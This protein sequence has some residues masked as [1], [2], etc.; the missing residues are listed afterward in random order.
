MQSTLTV[1][2]L[3][4]NYLVLPYV[5]EGLINSPGLVLLSVLLLKTSELTLLLILHVLVSG[6]WRFHPT[7]HWRACQIQLRSKIGSVFKI[8]KCMVLW[9][10]H[11]PMM[12]WTPVPVL[13][14]MEACLCIEQSPIQDV[15]K[16]K[17]EKKMWMLVLRRIFWGK[18][19]ERPIWNLLTNWGLFG[20]LWCRRH[21]RYSDTGL[22]SSLASITSPTQM[23][24]S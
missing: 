16:H 7:T 11:G 23:M 15:V 10:S 13:M 1:Y 9:L 12:D 3:Y 24:Q 2:Y 8:R 22:S 20:E 6:C 19:T 18:F 5:L 21:K 14:L 4:I 17:P